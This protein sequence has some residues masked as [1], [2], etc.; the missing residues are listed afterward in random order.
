MVVGNFW[1]MAWEPELTERQPPR[2]EAQPWEGTVPSTLRARLGDD[3]LA[4]LR[5]LNAQRTLQQTVTPNALAGAEL[6]PTAL[7][8]L[9]TSEGPA[10]PGA[11]LE[12]LCA[13]AGAEDGVALGMRLTRRAEQSLRDPEG[14]FS[15]RPWLQLRLRDQALRGAAAQLEATAGILVAAP[16]L[17]RR[18]VVVIRGQ[19][20]QV[21]TWVI[22]HEHAAAREAATFDAW[23][24]LTQEVL[25]AEHFELELE[26]GRSM[27]TDDPLSRSIGVTHIWVEGWFDWQEWFRA[28]EAGQRP[29]TQPFFELGRLQALQLLNEAGLVELVFLG[30]G[31]EV[32]AEAHSDARYQPFALGPVGRGDEHQEVLNLRKG[33]QGFTLRYGLTLDARAPFWAASC[34][35]RQGGETRPDQSTT[36]VAF[37]V[38]NGW[39]PDAASLDPFVFQAY[40]DL[41]VALL[42]A[43]DPLAAGGAIRAAVRAQTERL[44]APGELRAILELGEDLYLLRAGGSETPDLLLIGDP[45]WRPSVEDA[46]RITLATSSWRLLDTL[47]GSDKLV[48]AGPWDP[49]T[50]PSSCRASLDAMLLQAQRYTDAGLPPADANA[51]YRVGGL[52]RKRWVEPIPDATNRFLRVGL[53]DAIE[54]ARI[55]ELE[56]ALRASLDQARAR[57]RIQGWVLQDE[58]TA[59]G[60][61]P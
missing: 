46:L 4:E 31:I 34:S 47:P 43:E 25:G 28:I 29:D 22:G 53:L 19:A 5:A 8:F 26:P 20:R 9:G 51:R 33:R 44:V 32:D 39:Y 7:G 42:E 21:S 38:A 58:S 45:G 2:F 52:L 23:T 16:P 40:R 50:S 41:Q 3:P 15:A 48:G 12:R 18:P 54:P 36:A 30:H 35:N 17:G 13:A 55:V 24:T 27:A 60:D 10:M 61:G 56:D 59:A 11:M 49:C 57:R 1:I 14:E 6:L 37:L